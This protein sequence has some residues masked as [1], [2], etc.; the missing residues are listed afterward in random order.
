MRLLTYT[1]PPKWCQMASQTK[2][3]ADAKSRALYIRLMLSKYH[4][5][6][7]IL[8]S[9][10]PTDMTSVVA[11]PAI[12]ADVTRP[13]MDDNSQKP[14]L[15]SDLTAYIPSARVLLYDHGKPSDQDDLRSLGKNLLTQVHKERHVTV[16]CS[17]AVYSIMHTNWHPESEEASYFHLP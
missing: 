5:V 10:M 14:W 12:G 16:C 3:H 13:W 15:A 6:F 1:I 8:S 7:C 2:Q 4:R 11:V 17:H 9:Q